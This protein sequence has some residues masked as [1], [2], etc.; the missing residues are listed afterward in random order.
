MRIPSLIDCKR[1]AYLA[2]MFD[3]AM[4]VCSQNFKL[5]IQIVTSWDWTRIANTD[6]LHRH[7]PEINFSLRNSIFQ[8]QVRSQSCARVPSCKFW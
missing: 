4:V 2:S 1:Y 8:P 3:R 5:N 7:C 6:V